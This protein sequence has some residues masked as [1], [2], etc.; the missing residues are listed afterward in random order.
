M[1][2]SK[3]DTVQLKGTYSES[4]VVNVW[5]VC[6]RIKGLDSTTSTVEIGIEVHDL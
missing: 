6:E 1:V 5:I 2:K 3:N 4:L